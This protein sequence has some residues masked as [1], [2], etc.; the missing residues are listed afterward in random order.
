MAKMQVNAVVVDPRGVADF[1]KDNKDV[2]DLLARTA[3]EVQSEAQMTADAAQK[4]EGGRLDGYAQAGFSVVW[5][6]RGRRP[7]II[8]KS[9]ADAK[10]SMIAHFYTQKRDGVGHL[11]AALYKIT[12][13]G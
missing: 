8:I 13:R 6:L 4:G 3:G 2:R 12:N 10:T 1:L 5:E 11:R 9:N 7:R